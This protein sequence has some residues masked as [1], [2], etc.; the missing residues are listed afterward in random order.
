MERRLSAQP[1]IFGQVEEHLM[2]DMR[3][4]PNQG[5]DKRGDNSDTNR[6]PQEHDTSP[7]AGNQ[8]S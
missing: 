8:A 5:N 1:C 7:P 4:E 2:Q 3:D 6:N